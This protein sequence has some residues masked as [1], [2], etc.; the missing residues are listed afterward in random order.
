ML[1]GC[2]A[3]PTLLQTPVPDATEP[4][5]TPTPIP[6]IAATNANEPIT[7][8]IWLP[9]QFDPA[10]GSDAGIIFQERL[11]AYAAARP[12]LRVM[13][14]IKSETGTASL[15][16]NLLA[17]S[18]A[19]PL[20]MPDLVL[21]SSAD[22]YTAADSGLIIPFPS[23]YPTADDTDW[24]E[25]AAALSTRNDL[26]YGLPLAADAL[27][28]T[29]KP[30]QLEA[31][32]T[33]WDG[34]LNGGNT[35]YFPAASTSADFT[36]ACYLAVDGTLMN[37]A[38][39]TAIEEVPLTRTFSFF[40]D[41]FDNGVFPFWLTNYDTDELAWQNF[42]E[43]SAVLA[44]TKASRYLSLD[45]ETISAAPL[46]TQSGTAFTL[47]DGWLWTISAQ[48]PNR[49]IAA[50]EL[51]SFLTQ[52]EF[53]G[54]WTQATGVLPLRPSAL[55]SWE[56][57]PEKNLG[58]RLLPAAHAYPAPGVLAQISAPLSDAV[59]SILKG[60]LSSAEAVQ[61]VLGAINQ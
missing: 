45:S 18:Q 5:T 14:R 3:L 4:V 22:M 48:D 11:D 27:V 44:I 6:T 39:A 52:S 41:A 29:Y 26:R 34:I 20:A 49:Q 46:P 10:S 28:M 24:Y 23:N 19:A 38:G 33:S 21:L 50:A 2:N 17:A 55:S 60:E 59:I 42:S 9:P 7:L 31:I 36:L 58:G 15:L 30:S 32:P 47:M 12:G 40:A 16:N 56:D 37:E 57:G 8:L 61:Q 54:E 35:L 51:A 43:G 1:A 53:M 25:I 13:V